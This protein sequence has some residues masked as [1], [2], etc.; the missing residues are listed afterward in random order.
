MQRITKDY[1]HIFRIESFN[2]FKF[3]SIVLVF[4]IG[5]EVIA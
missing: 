1:P 5:L 4:F 2:L 3:C